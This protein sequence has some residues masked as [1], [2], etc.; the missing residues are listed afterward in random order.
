MGD[1]LFCKI[2][3]GEIP[4][5][6]VYEDDFCVAFL[7]IQPANPGHTLVVPKHHCDNLAGTPDAEFGPLFAAV[8]KVASAAIAAVG[9]SAFNI[10]VNN[11]PVAGQV[12]MHTHVHVVPRFENDGHRH[13]QK[14]AITPDEA[15]EIK[16]K[17][18]Q[19]LKS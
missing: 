10:I 2:V 12:I 3:K 5:D 14:K 16:A 11:G 6:R 8:K 15:K 17:M 1:C 19:I 13:W 7:D 18:S 4:A 9:A